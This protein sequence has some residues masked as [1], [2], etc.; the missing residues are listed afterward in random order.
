MDYTFE[1]VSPKYGIFVATAPDRFRAQIEA[2]T[3]HV[4]YEVTNAQGS[5]FYV[6]TTVGTK[7]RGQKTLYLHQLVWDLSGREPSD[8][9]DHRDANPLNNAEDNLR[10]GKDGG[11]QRNRPAR[12]RNNRSGVKGVGWDARRKKWYAGIRVDGK[13]IHLGRFA[14]I[15]E[16]QLMRDVAAVRHHGEF[17][18]LNPPP[19]PIISPDEYRALLTCLLAGPTI[20][21][22]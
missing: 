4:H 8:W 13:T 10:D 19:D 1:I 21:P 22:C 12:Q 3:W 6:Q 15:Q 20:G 7:K 11:N 2:H 16:A 9:V 5:Q 17:A 14:N 18:A